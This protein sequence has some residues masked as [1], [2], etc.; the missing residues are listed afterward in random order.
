[1][2]VDYARKFNYYLFLKYN[3]WNNYVGVSFLPIDNN[4]YSYMP[5]EVVTKE[6]YDEYVAQLTE[7][8]FDGTDSALELSEDECASGVCPVK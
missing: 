5:Q 6:R 7:V 4:V 2:T 8:D 3:N 1:M